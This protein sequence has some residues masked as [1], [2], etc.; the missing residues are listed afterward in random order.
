MSDNKLMIPLVV[1][2]DQNN[3]PYYVGRLQFPGMIDCSQGVVF[4]IFTS[5]EGAEELQIGTLV[6]RRKEKT[7]PGGPGG[8]DDQDEY[9][10]G[11]QRGR[12]PQY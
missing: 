11:P 7:G 1:K 5:E 2:R 3:K 6:D 4:M 9:A 10:R 12:P 8:Q